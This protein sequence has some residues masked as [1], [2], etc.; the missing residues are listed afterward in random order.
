MTERSEH[1]AV[2]HGDQPIEYVLVRSPRRRRTIGI[3]VEERGK[4]VVRAPLRVP[5]AMIEDFVRQKAN[6]I[7]ARQLVQELKGPRPQMPVEIEEALRREAQPAIEAAVERWSPVLG[8]R[9]SRVI[10]RSYKRRWGSCSADGTLRF[11]WRLTLLD[12]SALDYVV[13]HELAHLRE[14]NHARAFWAL[15]AQALPDFKE[16]RLML[17]FAHP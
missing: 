9:P 12:L 2:Q 14:R 15:V 7:E 8:C 13:V 5:L 16:R 4:V 1:H 11:N 6:W 10:V 17:R 3:T